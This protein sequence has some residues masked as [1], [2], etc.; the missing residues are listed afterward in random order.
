MEGEKHNPIAIIALLVVLIGVGFSIFYQDEIFDSPIS[1]ASASVSVESTPAQ[2]GVLPPPSGF[3]ND[4]PL[5]TGA[6]LVASMTTH[7]GEYGTLLSV[8][9]ESSEEQSQKISE[10]REWLTVSG[11]EI[12]EKEKD[13]VL[14]LHGAKSEGEVFVSVHETQEGSLIEVSYLLK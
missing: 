13:G 7:H 10:Y 11:Y 14:K 6:P 1:Q 4:I 5:E 2:N 9:Y 8:S 3:P 12:R